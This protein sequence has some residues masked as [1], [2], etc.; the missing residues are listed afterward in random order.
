ML[1][2]DDYGCIRCVRRSSKKEF[3]KI[4]GVVSGTF[5]VWGHAAAYY[6]DSGMTRV[7]VSGSF[8][9]I[10][11][12]RYSFN[13]LEEIPE[14]YRWVCKEKVRRVGIWPFEEQRKY[15]SLDEGAVA[16]DLSDV[17]EL[18]IMGGVQFLDVTN[19][20]E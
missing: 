19:I 18:V 4:L 17:K 8:L 7:V 20:E 12:K 2:S 5:Y 11:N 6:T 16:Q 10:V 3:P 15:W 1:T 13:S 9:T 14:E